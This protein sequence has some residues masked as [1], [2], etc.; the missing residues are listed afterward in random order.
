MSKRETDLCDVELSSWD[1]NAVTCPDLRIM[2]CVL[3]QRDICAKH[4]MHPK[5]G[6][7]VR[8]DSIVPSGQPGANTDVIYGPGS[9]Q[10]APYPQA[11]MGSPMLR[12]NICIGCR[13]VL[14]DHDIGEA[15]RGVEK[16]LVQFLAAAMTAKA[17]ETK[18]PRTP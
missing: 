16:Q 13:S 10:I 17:L 15:L 8:A 18:A 1:G 3:C 5:G 9:G 7:L 4:A 14:H 2:T 11:G 6:V 12:L